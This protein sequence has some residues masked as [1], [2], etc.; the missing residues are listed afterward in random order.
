VLSARPPLLLS[1]I[2][3][4]VLYEYYAIGIHPNGKSAQI[5]VDWILY[6]GAQC[7]GVSN[8]ELVFCH[9][10]DTYFEVPLLI[11]KKLFALLLR[12]HTVTCRKISNRNIGVA[13]I[14]EKGGGCYEVYSGKNQGRFGCSGAKKNSCYLSQ[15]QDVIWPLYRLDHPTFQF[16]MNIALFWVKIVRFQLWFFVTIKAIL[17]LS[18][19]L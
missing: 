10:S 2:L 12:L 6:D 14:F 9:H 5:P 3:Q 1:N 7:S 8:V 11:L 13:R 4:S 16:I 15:V 17:L 19:W 18:R